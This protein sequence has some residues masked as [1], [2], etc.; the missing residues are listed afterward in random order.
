MIEEKTTKTL[1]SK[2]PQPNR[3]GHD[4]GLL[5]VDT[6][7]IEEHNEDR[8]DSEL[9]IDSPDIYRPM[10]KME[11]SSGRMKNKYGHLPRRQGRGLDPTVESGAV[12]LTGS[13]SR[14]Q[15]PKFQ[16]VK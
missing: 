4:T 3:R 11:P 6:F 5:G 13:D 10:H 8:K 16:V 7:R 9:D 14:V 2:I 15:L 1:I 12:T